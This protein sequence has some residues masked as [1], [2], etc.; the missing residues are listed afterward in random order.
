MRVAQARSADRLAPQ[1]RR[2]PRHMR[3]IGRKHLQRDKALKGRVV[4][5]VDDPHAAAAKLGPDL[6]AADLR[7]P[8]MQILAMDELALGI[9]DRVTI[10]ASIGLWRDSPRRPNVW[11]VSWFVLAGVY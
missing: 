8:R 2:D 4:G 1:P 9:L 6:I 7:Q 5:M 10:L 11:R 3:Q